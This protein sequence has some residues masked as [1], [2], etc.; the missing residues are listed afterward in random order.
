MSQNVGAHLSHR[1]LHDF[2]HGV[3]IT[4]QAHGTPLDR[5]RTPF[6]QVEAKKS[7]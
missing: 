7:Q 5:R 4:I 6:Q 3:P 2:G 1:G